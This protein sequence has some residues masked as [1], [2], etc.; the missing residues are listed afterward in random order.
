MRGCRGCY[1]HWP[2]RKL[3]RVQ[4]LILDDWLRDPLYRSQARDLLKILDDRYGRSATI[5]VTQ[6][7][8][9]GW[10]R[11]IPHP[12]LADAILD[13]LIPNAYRLDLKGGDSM[14][15]IHSPLATDTT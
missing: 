3:A 15:K 10:H 13:R 8:V 2:W 1:R 11:R 9:S 12:T 14:R 4:L 5:V 7:P 6:V